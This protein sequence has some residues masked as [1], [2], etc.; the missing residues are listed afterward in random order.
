[1]TAKTLKVWACCFFLLFQSL[2]LCHS[3][4][5]APP[6]SNENEAL[7]F[8]AAMVESHELQ[9]FLDTTVTD[10][11]VRHPSLD[12]R[13][14]QVALIDLSQAGPPVTAHIN[15]SQR[16]YP[17]SVVKFIYLIAAYRWMEDTRI[18]LDP[19]WQ[20]H[21]RQMI[22][23]SDNQS[24]RWVFY[25]LTGTQPGDELPPEP[26]AQ[27]RERRQAVKRWLAALGLRNLHCVHPTYDGNGDLFGR[28]LQF[29]RDRSFVE[30][31]HSQPG[32][33]PNRLSVTALDTARLLALLATGHL[34]SAGNTEAVLSLMKRDPEEQKYLQR[35]I[36]GGAF[37]V[38]AVQV[39]SKSGTYGETFADAGI[40]K[41]AGLKQLVLAVFIQS[42]EPYRGNFI[43]EL[44]EQ[45]VK[46]IVSP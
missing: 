37:R 7:R 36:A 42:G 45:C 1:M 34:L 6:D 40:V 3:A 9:K 17:A 27:F 2:F 24:T 23:Y 22:R 30:E 39:Y 46:H 38:Q 5:A 15:G 16:I 26:Y 8:L 21:L 18:V 14:L 19:E 10:L 25:A 4:V 20:R 13:R 43:A 28:D 11:L 41:T 31:T 12:K 32:G 29:L 33:Y 35:R 44:T